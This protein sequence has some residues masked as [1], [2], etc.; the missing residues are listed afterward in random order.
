MPSYFQRLASQ[1]IAALM[2][3]AAAGGTVLVG[4]RALNL[5]RG[6]E[7]VET[8]PGGPQFWTFNIIDEGTIAFIVSLTMATWAAEIAAKNAPVGRAALLGL[9]SGALVAAVVISASKLG[10]SEG[11]PIAIVGV[12]AALVVGY[13]LRAGLNPYSRKIA[14]SA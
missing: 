14:E 11:I 13:I 5:F 4:G 9:F 12:I 10:A 6:T 1:L 3:I 8:G 7:I 2:S